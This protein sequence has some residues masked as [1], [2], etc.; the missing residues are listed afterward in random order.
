LRERRLA[1]TKVAVVEDGLKNAAL[2]VGTAIGSLAKKVGL[3]G[4]AAAVTPKTK[5][6]AAKKGIA[7]AAAFKKKSAPA[8]KSPPQ[9]KTVAKK[10]VAKTV[11]SKRTVPKKKSLA[12]KK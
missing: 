4:V 9:K 10:V 8:K 3:R 7:K 5:K 1:K 2:A 11:A 6:K 12:K